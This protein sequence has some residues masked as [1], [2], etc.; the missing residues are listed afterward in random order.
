MTLL[1]KENVRDQLYVLHSH[2]SNS[3]ALAAELLSALLYAINEEEAKVDS[4]AT[5]MQ[6]L[7][8]NYSARELFILSSLNERH[9]I[10]AMQGKYTVMQSSLSIT[11]MK[12]GNALAILADGTEQIVV[13]AY[14][15][16]EDIILILA[17]DSAHRIKRMPIVKD[18]IY[19]SHDCYLSRSRAVIKYVLK[20]DESH[21]KDSTTMD[22]E[23]TLR[24]TEQASN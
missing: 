16:G 18:A 1:T 3:L 21:E 5:T 20:S 6:Q 9:A 23:V 10:I 12:K 22:T 4:T 13:N 24:G 17:D 8:T 19:S 15:V 7:I 2:M 11:D 14:N